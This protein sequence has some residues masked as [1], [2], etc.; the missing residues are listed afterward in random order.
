MKLSH[1]CFISVHGSE[2]VW[3]DNSLQGFF[4]KWESYNTAD[5]VDRDRGCAKMSINNGSWQPE[6]C[7]KLLGFVCKTPIGKYLF[8]ATH[9]VKVEIAVW[10]SEQ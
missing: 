1:C 7:K 8:Q 3:T 5:N 6:L 4:D 9:K 2:W 10:V